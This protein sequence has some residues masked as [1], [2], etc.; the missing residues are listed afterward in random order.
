MGGSLA[1][2][3]RGRVAGLVA[4]EPQPAVRQMAQ[5]EG[6]A[7]EAVADLADAPPVDLLVLAAPVRAALALLGRLPELMPE[8][9]AVIDLGSTKRAV[10]AAMDALP[11]PFA[12]IGGHPMC[13][14]ETSGLAS[15]EADLF[16]EQTFILC[17]T[18]RTTPE[19]EASA[20]ALV[21][22]VGARPLIMDAADHD[23]AV[24]FVSHLPAVLS[25]ALMRAAADEQLWA[26][27]SS[28]F[29][30]TSR[31]AGSNPRMMLDILLTNRDAVLAALAAYGAEL[32]AAR[33]ALERG[34]EAALADWLAAAQVNYAAYRRFRS[35][36]GLA[37]KEELATDS[38]G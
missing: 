10:V 16:R 13:G 23:R 24:A 17:P 29:R 25:A 8:G 4:N 31:L 32:D 36:E 37:G 1:Q 22:A 14:K 6:I 19:L 28:G 12:A 30:D 3:L 5:R 26:V 27:G 18:R 20:L 33:A 2:A 38:R 9:C 15:A 11:P 34:D 35:G 21:A 7:G